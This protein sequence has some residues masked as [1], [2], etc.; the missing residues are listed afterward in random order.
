MTDLEQLR[1][2]PVPR[3]AAMC[4]RHARRIDSNFGFIAYGLLW[5]FV[6]NGLATAALF[7]GIWIVGPKPGPVGFT[8]VMTL[9]AGAFIGAWVMFGLWVRRRRGPAT[10][11]FRDGTVVDATVQTVRRLS[12]RGAPFTHATVVFRDATRERKAGVSMGGHPPELSEGRTVPLLYIPDY[13][14]CAAF[15]VAGKLIAASLARD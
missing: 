6:A 14:Y 4:R 8:F 1:N 13:G 15:P 9:W 10:R 3:P 5:F 7:L 11:L 12:M 2:A